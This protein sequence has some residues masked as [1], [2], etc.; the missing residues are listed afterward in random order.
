MLLYSCMVLLGPPIFLAIAWW[1]WS[2]R[3][4]A[5]QSAWRATVLFAG[6]LCGS[7]NVATYF[8]WV[9]LANH[10]FMRQTPQWRIFDLSGNVGLMFVCGALAGASIGVGKARLPLAVSAILGFVMWLPIGV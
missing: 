10:F 6:L 7:A 5:T 9:P 3:H 4:Q 1:L 2:R 8:V